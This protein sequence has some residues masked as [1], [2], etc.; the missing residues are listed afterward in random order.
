MGAK[1]TEMQEKASLWIFEKT[2]KKGKATK[3]WQ[4]ADDL[5][6]DKQYYKEV[7]SIYPALKHPES[8]EGAIWLESIVSQ[9][10]T[11]RQQFVNG[12]F[13]PFDEFDRSDEGGFMSYIS[14]LARE[15]YGYS[16]KDTW[17]PAD[18]WCIRNIRAA[19]K[20]IED[21]AGPQNT[22]GKPKKPEGEIVKLN[23]VLK[24]LY[25]NGKVKGSS[26][27]AVVGISL[28]L[29]TPTRGVGPD[30]KKKMMYIAHYEEVNLDNN[31]FKTK[32]FLTDFNIASIKLNLLKSDGALRTVSKETGEK[33]R[34]TSFGSQDILISVSN[35]LHKVGGQVHRQVF[36]FTIKPVSTSSF[37]NLKF[38]PTMKNSGSARLG[39]APVSKVKDQ[40]RRAGVSFSNEWKGYPATLEQYEAKR[41]YY[42]KCWSRAKNAKGPIGKVIDKNALGESWEEVDKLI[43]H[44]F[45]DEN[46]RSPLG[47]KG[48]GEPWIA[49]AKLM[50]LDLLAKMVA[51]GQ[52]A[53]GMAKLNTAFTW[54]SYSAQKKN[55]LP[56]GQFGPFGKLY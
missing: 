24:T 32:E 14:R 42:S 50:E 4:T 1:E 28:K 56:T 53:S 39:K 48:G 7:C 22:W 43:Q 17:N 19:K 18:V 23:E 6:N 26:S 38:E 3:I 30:G 20:M 15:V 8:K 12:S 35:E 37:N 9:S 16:Q 34:I 10:I 45:T 13:R 11:M 21:V 33:K 2:L 52:D 47:I 46:K 54:L 44:V 51:V 31:L 25:K 55:R 41:A 27:P 40:L 29:I 36:D 5:I 49:C